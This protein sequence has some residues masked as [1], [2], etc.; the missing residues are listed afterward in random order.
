[1]K[2]ALFGLGKRKLIAPKKRTPLKSSAFEC[3]PRCNSARNAV[4]HLLTVATD[5]TV[6]ELNAFPYFL[7][8]NE[9]GELG[10]RQIGKKHR[11]PIL[12]LH[13]HVERLRLD[14]N[15]ESIKLSC[16]VCIELNVSV[17]RDLRFRFAAD[18]GQY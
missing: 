2:W 13:V 8:M 1:M 7:T 16:V 4:N 12:E 3:Q 10:L 5:E 9:F 11:T 18:S 17:N 6:L 15:R 14:L